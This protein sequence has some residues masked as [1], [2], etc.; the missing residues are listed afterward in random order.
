MGALHDVNATYYSTG[1][2]AFIGNAAG[3]PSDKLG[4]VVGVGFKIN[5]PF[6]GIKA[7]TS[8]RSS[9]TPQGAL[10]YIFQTPNSNWGVRRQAIAK[11]LA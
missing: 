3:H 4:W 11:A 7:T 6:I 10:R 9:T 5:S 8:R 1:A 2:A